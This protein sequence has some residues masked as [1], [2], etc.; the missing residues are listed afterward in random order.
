M[1]TEKQRA[2]R[3]GYIGGSEAAA[4]LGLSRW[5]TPLSVW[6]EKTGQIE[7]E[8]IS[9]KLHVKL[10]NKLEQTVADLFMEETGKK[11][12]KVNET[13]FHKKYPF[14]GVNLDRRVVGERAFLECKTASAWKAKEW[15][16]EEIPREYILQV[17]HGLAVAGLERAYIAV[18][19]GNQAFKWKVIERDEKALTD[20]VNREVSF[21]TEFVETKIM[22][23]V[24]GQDKDTLSDLF[25][26]A[27]EGKTI[28]LSDEANAVAEG[29][30]GLNAD[31][32]DLENRIEK[33][34]NELRAMLGDAEAGTTGRYK[35]YWTNTITRRLDTE[36]LKKAHPAIFEE[37]RKPSTQRRFLIKTIT[38]EETNGHNS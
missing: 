18:L 28:Q 27:Q 20:L 35:I 37:F 17:M 15:D 13:I 10:G 29:L 22:P 19:I 6:A 3:I 5:A 11:V 25:P 36:A 33:Q 12:Q 30:D 4:V 32:R 16:G 23:S 21:W 14:L 31:L 38:T 8:D 7:P 24:M 2:E 9:E 34:Q 26:V 1:L